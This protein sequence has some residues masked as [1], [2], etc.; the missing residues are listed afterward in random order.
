MEEQKG[1]SAVFVALRLALA[2]IRRWLSPLPRVETEV[3]VK[4]KKDPKGGAAVVRL[5]PFTDTTGSLQLPPR[6]RETVF[7]SK[8]KTENKKMVLSGRVH[9]TVEYERKAP[10][11]FRTFR[12]ESWVEALDNLRLGTYLDDRPRRLSNFRIGGRAEAEEGA[13]HRSP[14]RA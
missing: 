12:E 5:L 6:A 13:S 10:S 4:I 11:P 1:I 9:K 14:V 7:E 2:L 3:Q 8:S